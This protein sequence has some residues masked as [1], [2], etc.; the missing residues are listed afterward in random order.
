MTAK[1][2]SIS[3]VRSMIKSDVS[4]VDLLL[5]TVIDSISNNKNL[6]AFTFFGVPED[7]PRSCSELRQ[8]KLHGVPFV[9]KDNINTVH[10]PTAAGTKALLS[11]VTAH[12][13]PL[14]ECLLAEGA[15][16]VGKTG[17]HELALGITSNN[18]ATGAV[19]N[20]H[21]ATRIP[22]GSSGGTAAAIAAGI[23]PFGLGSD[24]GGSVRIPAGLCGIVGFR[25]SIGRYCSEGVVPI[26]PSRDTVGPM[27]NNVEDVVLLDAILTKGLNFKL[28][29][30]KLSDMKLGID[31]KVLTENLEPEVESCFSSVLQKLKEARVEIVD[32]TNKLEEIWEFTIEFRK[33]VTNFE[34]IPSLRRYLD[35]YAPN[36][37]VE[38][39]VAMI[40]SPDVKKS[41]QSALERNLVTRESYEFALKQTL[42]KMREVYSHAIEGL[43]G[44][45]FP[46]TP[47]RATK[48]GVDDLVA[49]NGQRV[50]MFWTFIRNTSLA[51]CVGSPAISLPASV[52]GLPVG[53][54]VDG[55]R[56]KD[57]DL[58]AAALSI[59]PLL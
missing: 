14:I 36:I 43:D 45:I 35:T 49:L 33:T 26:S 27:A 13:S 10:F 2:H 1:L 8:G 34:M 3:Y 50:P 52:R 55:A 9:A 54:E 47:L 23:V 15:V 20:P 25:P 11:N 29:P 16:L 42:P 32:V 30:K 38:H 24:T 12:N 19:R 53:I 21:D 6:N 17:M 5:K 28:N 46:T 57:E 51:S 40:A 31:R 44:I 39:L 4:S 41:Y 22:G 37:S 7:E 59:A 58:L 18:Y 56:N 48:I